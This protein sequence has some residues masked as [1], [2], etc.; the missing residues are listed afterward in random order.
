MYH[1]EQHERL[2]YYTFFLHFFNPLF[3]CVF[4]VC[5]RLWPW[6]VAETSHK[7]G[8][9][10]FL[11][12]F[13]FSSTVVY[14]CEGQNGSTQPAICGRR[15]IHTI[16]RVQYMPKNRLVVV[17]VW[18]KNTHIYNVVIH[19]RVGW[20]WTVADLPHQICI[21]WQNPSRNWGWKK[22]SSLMLVGNSNNTDNNNN[23]NNFLSWLARRL[24]RYRALREEKRPR[25]R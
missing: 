3:V 25:R 18:P 22:V 19:V 15:T 12:S 21:S 20:I 5:R 16:I 13:H 4:V 7:Q 6:K 23:N 11:L 14:L 17:V 8:H 2:L 10:C 1:P 9:F 24:A